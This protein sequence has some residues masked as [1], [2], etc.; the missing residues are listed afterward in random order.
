MESLRLYERLIIVA[1]VCVCVH[2]RVCVACRGATL[3]GLSIP[4]GTGR[5]AMACPFSNR[6]QLLLVNQQLCL[7]PRSPQRGKQTENALVRSPA[8]LARLFKRSKG[9]LFGLPSR[10]ADTHAPA[11]H[12]GICFAYVMLSQGEELQVF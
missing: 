9:Q 4:T 11:R 10:C 3:M 6:L 2:A 1:G 8:R 7:P 12:A 5:W